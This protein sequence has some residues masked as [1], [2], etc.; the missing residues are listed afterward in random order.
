MLFLVTLFLATLFLATLFLATLHILKS[1][2]SGG[3]PPE[4][5]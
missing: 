3:K 2:L 5:N 4:R 1:A